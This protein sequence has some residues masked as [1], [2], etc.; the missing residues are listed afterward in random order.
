MF[1]IFKRV[2]KNTRSPPFFTANTKK[3]LPPVREA[4]LF[5]K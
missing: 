4:G 3:G 1:L 5:L 2:F